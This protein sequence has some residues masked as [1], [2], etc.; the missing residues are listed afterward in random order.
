MWGLIFFF[1]IFQFC[2]RFVYFCKLFQEINFGFYSFSLNNIYLIFPLI[3]MIFI[4]LFRFFCCSCFLKLI[5][6]FT[7]Y[8]FKVLCIHCS[9]DYSKGPSTFF[10]LFIFFIGG[11]LLY[12]SVLVSAAQ[13]HESAG[14]IHTAPLFEPIPTPSH[15]FRWDELSAWAIQQ[16]AIILHQKQL[17]TNSEKS[18]G[19]Y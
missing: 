9:F 15:P 6:F 19:T 5:T 1:P 4:F 2:S 10:F 3:F 12:N 14:C 18:N 7:E 17:L 8:I 13:Q 16:L 11:Q